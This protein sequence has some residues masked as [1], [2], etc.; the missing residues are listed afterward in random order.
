MALKKN[1]VITLKIED[2]TNLGFG[3]GRYMGE[4]IFVS[5]T[6]PGDEA[7]CVVIKPYKSYS[8]ARPTRWQRKKKRWRPR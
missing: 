2:I 8:I 4:V 1:Q 5:D 7:E 6:V 3:V